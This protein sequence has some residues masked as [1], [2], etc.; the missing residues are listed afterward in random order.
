MLIGYGLVVGLN[1]TGDTLQ[2]SPF[3]QQA[4]QTMLERLGVNTRGAN[5]NTKNIAA[6]M[7]TANL[8]PFAAQGTR[9]DVT[10]SALG[11]AKSLQGGTLLVTPLLGGGRRSLRARARAARGRR[12]LGAGRGGIG[13]ARRADLGPHR[14]R[15]ASSSAKSP[16]SLPS[17]RRCACRCAIPISPRRSASPRRSTAIVGEP[18]ATAT[19]PA[20][21]QLG[22]AA[23]LYRQYRRAPDRDRAAEGRTRSAGEGGDRRTVRRHRHGRRR[24]HLHGR[25]RARQPHHPRH[26]NAASQPAAA[27]LAGK[28]RR[29]VVPRTEIEVDEETGKQ[30]VVLQDGVSL[31][32]WSTA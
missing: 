29:E 24:A 3:T 16:S 27:L 15:R 18:A 17:G 7:V 28:A 13:H 9:I 14:Q 30:L 20:T 22:P 6:V 5:V 4:L 32:I 25:H 1:G 19:D 12:L 21:V 11:D 2:N 31:Q 23:E 26:R 8:P 10:V